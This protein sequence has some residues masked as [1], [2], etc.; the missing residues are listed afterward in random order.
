M[1]SSD[2]D[3]NNDEDENKEKEKKSAVPPK[4][5]AIAPPSKPVMPKKAHTAKIKKEGMSKPIG[6]PGSPSLYIKRDGSS[7]PSA[8]PTSPARPSSPLKEPRP[9]SPLKPS[10]PSRHA[11]PSHRAAS[12]TSPREQNGKKRK[13]EDAG[14]PDVKRKKDDL[15]T[16][17]EVIDTLRGRIMTTKEFLLSFR[18]RI[19]NNDKNRDIITNLLKKVAKRNA[20]SD[21][22]TRMLE[23]KPEYQ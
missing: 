12:P 20:S 4:K 14:S 19:K 11:S 22:S 1:N 15:I 9:S 10:S 2:D 7:S 3:E 23:L 18:K 13:L 8:K 16:E 17:Q 5:K 6:R 21:P